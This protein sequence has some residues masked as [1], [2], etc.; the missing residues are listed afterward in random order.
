MAV[1]NVVLTHVSCAFHVVAMFNMQM[2]LGT[3]VEVLHKTPALLTDFV[4]RNYHGQPLFVSETTATVLL[5][6]IREVSN[7][8]TDRGFM[9]FFSPFG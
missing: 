8:Y 4:I 7:D 3:L 9:V 6:R 5:H 1:V 2:V